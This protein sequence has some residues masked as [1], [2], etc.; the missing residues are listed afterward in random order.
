MTMEAILE[1]LQG[2]LRPQVEAAGGRVFA[3]EDPNEVETKFNLTPAGGWSLI[4]CWEGYEPFS[5]DPIP[6]SGLE[7][8]TFIFIVETNKG[9][10]LQKG[11]DIPKFSRL[12]G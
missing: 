1:A 12:V 9:L 11:A 5:D 3:E 6:N 4:I 2:Y 8:S 10:P 7:W